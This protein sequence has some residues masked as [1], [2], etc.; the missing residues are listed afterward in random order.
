MLAICYKKQ[1]VVDILLAQYVLA[2]SLL[3]IFN[4]VSWKALLSLFLTLQAK[5]W[6]FAFQEGGGR[7]PGKQSRPHCLASCLSG[8]RHSSGGLQPR[9]E[10]NSELKE[11]HSLYSQDLFRSSCIRLL[12]FWPH[13]ESAYRVR[14]N[15]K[16]TKKVDPFQNWF[17]V[18]SDHYWTGLGWFKLFFAFQGPI[19]AV[20]GQF[21]VLGV[22]KGQKFEISKLDH[23][24][25]WDAIFLT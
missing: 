11:L 16:S 21:W 17:F 24:W 20:G 25:P 6:A 23:F 18:I 10:T 7:Q 13:Q 15:E 12:L 9:G 8:R 3:I 1:P 14:S 5:G 19:G 22:L 4:S 2:Q